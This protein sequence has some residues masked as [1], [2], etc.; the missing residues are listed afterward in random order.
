[1]RPGKL[2]VAATLVLALLGTGCASDN[3][4][5][6]PPV[7]VNDPGQSG[8]E[9]INL[10]PSSSGPSGLVVGGA[11]APP[12]AAGEVD[13]AGAYGLFG[14]AYHHMFQLGDQL[15]D[16]IA[17]KLALGAVK[18]PAS[19]LRANFGRLFG[20]HA[21]LLGAA[22]QKRATGARDVEAAINL[23]GVNATALGGVVRS[24]AKEEVRLAFVEQWKNHNRMLLAVAAASLAPD[25]AARERAL[26]ELTQYQTTFSRFLADSFR[27]DRAVLESL[28][29]D[30]VL[31]V[32]GAFDATARGDH[33]VAGREGRV[34]YTHM[35]VIA[36]ALAEPIA[37]ES[38][39]GQ[40]LTPASDLRSNVDRLLAEHAAMAALA[41]QRAHD[42][43]PDLAAT[44]ETL[45]ANGAEIAAIVASG[46]GEEAGAA[47]AEQWKA[48]LRLLIDLGVATGTGDASAR[49]T[50][51]S[52]LEAYT[53]SFSQFLAETTG[54]PRQSLAQLF[55][56][57]LEQLRGFL[58]FY[59]GV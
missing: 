31:Q 39:M 53:G 32:L 6:A 15:A 58:D 57:H 56:R 4:E 25:P 13:L 7:P 51:L 46:F 55:A 27:I 35:F 21:V 14:A 36:D 16:A 1:M 9:Q 28:V 44:S 33:A 34:A 19:D 40:A 3:P 17:Q 18:G 43:S 2:V 52:D 48:H 59:S 29:T 24:V 11:Q 45:D 47:F 22:M 23:L 26:G 42:R 38:G 50:A 10:R 30:H 5:L 8:E 54:L 12:R 49:Q 20:E 37:R 41:M